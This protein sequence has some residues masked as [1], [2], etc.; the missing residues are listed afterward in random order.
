MDSESTVYEEAE[1][2][3]LI[4]MIITLFSWILY[5]PQ[6]LDSQVEAEFPVLGQ[7]AICTG[8]SYYL[9]TKD[10]KRNRLIALFW[11]LLVCWRRNLST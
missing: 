5:H 7:L 11:C 1:K 2:W 6:T 9:F 3:M 8:M 10:T 4:T